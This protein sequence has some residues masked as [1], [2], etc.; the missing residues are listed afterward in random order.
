MSWVL[1]EE[2]LAVLL[3]ILLVSSVFAIAQFYNAG[4]GEAFSELGLL[5][6]EG[7]IGDYP[8]EVL[9]GTPFKLNIYIGNHE[10][11]AVYYRILVK[12]GTINSTING[13]TPMLAPPIMEFR[14]VLMHNSSVLIPANITLY[15]EMQNA[16]LVFE[17]WILNETSGN[18]EYYGRWNQLWLNVT[19]PPGIEIT[20]SYPK[21]LESEIESKLIEGFLSIRRAEV[22]GGNVAQMVRLLNEAIEEAEDGKEDEA[23]NLISQILNLE[24]SIIELGREAERNRLYVNLVSS[25]SAVTIGIALFLY[26][27]HK[28]W[29]LWAKYHS[30]FGITFNKKPPKNVNLGP[31]EVKIKR[32][33]KSLQDPKVKSILEFSNKFGLKNHEAARMV[34]RMVRARVVRLADPNP[35]ETFIDY[36]SSKYNLGFAISTLLVALTIISVYTSHLHPALSAM[37]IILGTLFT[38]FMPGYSLI[39]TLYPSET[40]LKPLERL[41]LSIGLSL[42]LVP[43]VGLVLNYTPWGIRLN[44][45]IVAL[46]ALTLTLLTISVY[47]KFQLLKLRVLAENG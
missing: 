24:P 18:F 7:K 23:E 22:S 4:R 28:I 13:T 39:E 26:L 46:S 36:V 9:A 44:P 32:L 34:Y 10:W 3:A 33:I 5:G 37:R 35:P 25:I 41:A 8:K 11:K 19:K 17:M 14:K 42:A 15:E 30:K 27:R 21:S 29:L 6:P 16:R 43:L 2:V 31:N 40:D 20:P 47:R 12:V 38:L 45:V 1:D